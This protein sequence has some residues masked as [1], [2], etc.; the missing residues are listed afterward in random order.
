[1][2]VYGGMIALGA[3]LGVIVLLP[4][5]GCG[6]AQEFGRNPE[7]FWTSAGGERRP[8]STD[9]KPYCVFGLIINNFKSYRPVLPYYY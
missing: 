8:T 6:N 3:A 9:G 5:Q 4:I 2:A 1:M 7:V